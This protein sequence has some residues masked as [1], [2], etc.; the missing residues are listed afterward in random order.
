M[1]RPIS[2]FILLP[3]LLIAWLWCAGA[4]YYFGLPGEGLPGLAA[5]M[6][7][8]SFPLPFLVFG[9]RA[10]AVATVLFSVLLVV[11]VWTQ[12]R[13][14]HDRDWVASVARLP[15][16][17]VAG[18]RY[19]IRN[20][21]NFDYRSEQDFDVAYYNKSYDIKRLQTVDYILSYWDGNEAVAHALLSFGFD[22]GDR[23]VVSVETRLEK[24][25]IQ[26]GL[27]GLFKQY[28]LIYV[29]AD[30]RDI[31]RLRSNFR[32]EQVYL[33]PTTLEPKL[34]RKLFQIVID[35]VNE[36]EQKPQFYNTLTE[37]C[38]T[39]LAFKFKRVTQPKSFWDYR[40][41]AIGYSDQLLYEDGKIRTVLPFDRAKRY[42]H[43]NQYVSDQTT[44]MNY[45]EKIRPYLQ[46]G[47]N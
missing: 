38:F 23:L 35:G 16:V 2:Y 28:E 8:L 3:L 37:N 24:Q 12:K 33:Y 34:V 45:S 27:G 11:L 13:P 31:I 32:K 10:K 43:I 46:L 22:N 17:Q 25:E 39:S 42:F 26:S 30:E 7:G 41:L 44:A 4:I 14:S 20:I 6:F 29:L 36:I 9:L 15:S 18:D 21:R 5:L 19:H 47:E 40:R 1:T